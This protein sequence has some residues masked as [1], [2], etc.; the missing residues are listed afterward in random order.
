MNRSQWINN[1]QLAAKRAAV[2]V[3]ALALLPLAGCLYPDEYTPSNQ[4][5]AKESVS[6]V[7]AAVDSYRKDTGLLPIENASEGTPQYEKFRLDFAK[8]KRM[9]YVTEI[10]KEAFESG[11]SGQFLIIDEESDPKVKLLDL[12]VYQSIGT[13]QSK[14]NAYVLKHKGKQPV[15]DEIYPDFRRID[16]KALGIDDPAIRSMYT[17]RVL[18]LMIDP[19]SAV[20]AD[21]GID[22]VKALEKSEAKPSETDDLRAM[23]ADESFY[24]PVKSP[25][26]R[27]V[28]GEPRAF[29]K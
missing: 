1:G 6:A 5:S 21:Y 8:L 13:V 18:E 29:L 11:G 22:I 15:A 17:G 23:L 2:L 26:Y 20:Y 9:G 25:V 4:V 12:A 10:P 7:Q 16:Y 24:V 27:L 3:C 14:V 19:G 28:D